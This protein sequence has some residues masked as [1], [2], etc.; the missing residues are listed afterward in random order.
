M[1]SGSSSSLSP[2]A[3]G[4]K[5]GPPGRGR[6]LVAAATHPHIQSTP[7]FAEGT[8]PVSPATNKMKRTASTVSTATATATTQP[9]KKH[10]TDNTTTT[11][12]SHAEGK[13]GTR[14]ASGK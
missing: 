12:T 1:N 14:R 2:L 13:G 11:N 7:A 10:R 9:S 8:A 3:A 5:R 6:G 4:G